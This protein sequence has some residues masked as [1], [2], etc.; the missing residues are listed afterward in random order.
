M[1]ATERTDGVV[2][3]RLEHG[4]ASALDL[5][6][7]MALEGCLADL[8]VPEVRAVVLTG[9]GSIFSA[10]VDLPRLVAGGP[11]YMRAFLPALSRA[12]RK[13]VFFSKPVVAAV[14][15]HAIAG[16]CILACAADVRLMAEGDG[17]IGVPE[18]RVGVPFPAA[19]LEVMR[20]AVP[21]PH[22]ERLVTS[23][24]T[25][26]AETAER[27]GLVH[28]A[29]EPGMLV[30]RALAEA[31]SYASIQPEVFALHK[32]QCRLHLDRRWQEI[33]AHF[34]ERIE[35]L[36][37]APETLALIQAYVDRTLKARRQG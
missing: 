15:G 20:E 21:A 14:N 10:G 4:K 24:V 37:N 30:E 29:V 26:D 31:R 34:E 27:F 36:W 32:A 13:L 23:G 12:F 19:A 33:D 25:V 16:G 28:E 2:T 35:A 3:V 8:E 17:R 11:D 5:E 1:I 7:C 6:L 18:L 22:F 9:T